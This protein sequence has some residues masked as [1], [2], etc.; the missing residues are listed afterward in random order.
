MLGN[1]SLVTNDAFIHNKH[2]MNLHEP[3][4][5]VIYSTAMLL[6][7][8]I[9]VVDTILGKLSYYYAIDS[10]WNM[11]KYNMVYEQGFCYYNRLPK[12]A[13]EYVW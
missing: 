3:A 1:I 5:V 10:I 4:R 12:L 8:Y 13:L 7:E 2:A 9:L 6:N 11:V